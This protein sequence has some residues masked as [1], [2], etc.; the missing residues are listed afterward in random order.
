MRPP[1]ERFGMIGAI[2]GVRKRGLVQFVKLSVYEVLRPILIGKLAS[3]LEKSGLHHDLSNQ[4]D[5]TDLGECFVFIKTGLVYSRRYGLQCPWNSGPRAVANLLF[6][7]LAEMSYLSAIST[8]VR[9]PKRLAGPQKVI[10]NAHND[11]Y[12]H[13]IFDSL[14]YAFAFRGEPVLSNPKQVILLDRFNHA[15]DVKLRYEVAGEGEFCLS[16]DVVQYQRPPVEVRAKRLSQEL[17]M[18]EAPE[19]ST[20]IYLARESAVE[21]RV[22]NES[23]FYKFLRRERFDIVV[24]EA[25]AINEVARIV[26]NAGL[27]ISISGAGLANLIWAEDASVLILRPDETSVL[28]QRIAEALGLDAKT[29][30]CARVGPD[31]H[32]D[33]RELKAQIDSIGSRL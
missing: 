8:L 17:S 12:Y 15:F 7:Q 11:N 22:A 23:Q 24:P 10:I 28:Y 9:G 33:L 3:I 5:E 16:E 14:Y 13:A 32:V 6:K 20:R 2:R 1:F 19:G 4:A 18:Q 31:L 25:H 21:R 27:I 26:A 29:M 30:D